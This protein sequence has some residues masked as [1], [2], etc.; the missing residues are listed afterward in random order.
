MQSIQ[1][2]QQ[3]KFVLHKQ[4]QIQKLFD[5]HKQGWLIFSQLNKASKLLLR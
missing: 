3:E 5:Q 4:Q 2:E 1:Q